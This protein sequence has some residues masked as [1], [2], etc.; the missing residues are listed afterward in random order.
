MT[1][2]RT[3]AWVKSVGLTL[4]KGLLDVV[5]TTRFRA[6]AV[7]TVRDAFNLPDTQTHNILSARLHLDDEA[8]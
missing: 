8:I 1:G 4:Y 2:N 3:V 6:L 5:K 7:T